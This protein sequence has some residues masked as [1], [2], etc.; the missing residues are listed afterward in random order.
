MKMRKRWLAL[1][2]ALA[3][4]AGLP[5][6]AHAVE[7][8][9]ALTLHTTDSSDSVH[10][11]EAGALAAFRDLEPEHWAYFEIM[12]AANDHGCVKTSGIE[13]WE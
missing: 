2:L 3:L 11:V 1:L 12:E 5:A 9:V 13:H 7:T 6:A 10:F 4:C 8:R